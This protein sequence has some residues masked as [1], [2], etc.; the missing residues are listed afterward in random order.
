MGLFIKPF[1]IEF[2]FVFTFLDFGE[3]LWVILVEWK[4]AFPMGTYEEMGKWR[5]SGRDQ[6]RISG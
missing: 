1:E 4:R 2:E 6:T 5:V 3:K